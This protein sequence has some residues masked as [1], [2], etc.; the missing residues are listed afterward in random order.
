[1][2][3]EKRKVNWAL[4]L[5]MSFFFGTLGIDRFLMGQVGF[6]LLKLF[7]FGGV[8]IWYAIDFIR[9]AMKSDFGGSI[10]WS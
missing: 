2:T 10:E 4:T 6:G 8:F 9:I 1:M 5:I 7:T 3:K